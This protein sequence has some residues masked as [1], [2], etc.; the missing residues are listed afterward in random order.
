M[1]RKQLLKCKRFLLFC[2][3][4]YGINLEQLQNMELDYLKKYFVEWYKCPEMLY[5]P[6]GT[7]REK[8]RL[9]IKNRSLTD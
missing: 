6:K 2:T 1:T 7:Q 4:E 5:G 8:V 9:T 3:L